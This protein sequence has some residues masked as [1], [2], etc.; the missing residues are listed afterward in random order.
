VIANVNS[1]VE[2]QGNHLRNI[3][4][5]TRKFNNI[6][7]IT[8]NARKKSFKKFGYIPGLRSPGISVPEGEQKQLGKRQV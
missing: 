8:K 3:G 1:I 4:C 2:G 5:K 7:N 6:Q